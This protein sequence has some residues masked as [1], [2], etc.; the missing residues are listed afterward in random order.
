[1]KTWKSMHYRIVN[2]RLSQQ[3]PPL[4][5]NGEHMKRLVR[6]ENESEIDTS[7]HRVDLAG[8]MQ[9]LQQTCLDD[10][11]RKNAQGRQGGACLLR[12]EEPRGPAGQGQGLP[13]LESSGEV[14]LRHREAARPG[15]A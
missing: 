1:M 14:L 5:E 15:G 2:Q 13:E 11:L 7:D 4:R 8:R 6:C 3:V 9:G 12:A 10:P